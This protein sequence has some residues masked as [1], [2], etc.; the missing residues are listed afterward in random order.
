MDKRILDM[1]VPSLICFLEVTVDVTGGFVPCGPRN[2]YQTPS[3][4]WTWTDS[5]SRICKSARHKGLGSELR[6]YLLSKLLLGVGAELQKTH[7]HGGDVHV[8]LPDGKAA[9]DQVDGGSA[10][11]AVRGQL[12]ARRLQQQERQRLACRA[13]R[14]RTGTVRRSWGIGLALLCW[15]ACRGEHAPVRCGQSQLDSNRTEISF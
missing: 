10:D 12:G 14:E 8:G 13:E 9:A 15:T 6:R 11:G 4:T 2:A 5:R 7:E 3:A 1:D